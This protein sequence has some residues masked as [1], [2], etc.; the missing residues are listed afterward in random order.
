MNN[1]KKILRKVINVITLLFLLVILYFAYEYYQSNNFN[2]FI[3][4]EKTYIHQNLKE[5]KKQNIHKK[6]V[7]KYLL[8]NLMMQC[9]I[10]KYK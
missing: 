1:N 10:K 9:F 5:I 7:I 2:D 6:V 3:R 8:M 4:S